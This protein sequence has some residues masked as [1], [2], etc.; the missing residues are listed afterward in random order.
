MCESRM[1][2]MFILR[3]NNN[4]SIKIVLQKYKIDVILDL[5]GTYYYTWLFLPIINIDK[6]IL[7]T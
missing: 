5:V 2:K 4:K 6:L 3:I 1:V 7:I